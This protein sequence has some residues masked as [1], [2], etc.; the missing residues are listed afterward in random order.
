MRRAYG[1][2]V[3]AAAFVFASASLLLGDAAAQLGTST[4][5]GQVCIVQDGYG[6]P[7]PYGKE[8]GSCYGPP[9]PGATVHLT[10]PG[11]QGTPV[12][13]VDQ[14]A[15]TDDGGYFSFS[16]LDDGTYTLE[17]SHAGFASAEQ[18][19]EVAGSAQTALS[20]QPQE[21]D[22]TGRILDQD[23]AGIAGA[24]A[25]FCCSYSSNYGGSA[26]AS[27]DGEG[28]FEVTVLAGW[29]SVT[30]RA[31]GFQS[32]YDYRLVDG[33]PLEYTLE[34][35]PPQDATLTGTV[36][37]QDGRAVAN[38]RVFTYSYNCCYDA[39]GSSY[40]PYYG[41][42]N[43]TDT[44]SRGRYTLH[45]YSGGLSFRAEK[46]GYAP[47]YEDFQVEQGETQVHDVKILKYPEKNAHVSGR[48]TDG[49]TGKGLRYVSI[50][51][52]SPAFGITECS[53]E[54][55]SGSNGSGGSSVPPAATQ[56]VSPGIAY[57]EPYPYYDPGC[58]ITLRTDGTFEGD[59]TPGYT[60]VQVWYQ[61][62]LSCTETGNADGSVERT[63]GRDY[64]SWS[65]TLDLPANHDATVNIAMRARPLPDAV[66]SG[67]LVD[68]ETEEAIPGARISLSNQDNYGY[69]Y[70][71][72][73][74]DGSY[75]IRLRTGYHE[76]WVYAEGY[77]PWQGVLDVPVG[78]DIP[79][80]VLLTAGREVYG[81]YCCVVYEGD[82][83]YA[84]GYAGSTASP[85]APMATSTRTSAPS[86]PDSS[87]DL[88]AS[89]GEGATYDDLKGGLGPYDPDQRAREI[90]AQ[91]A[92]GGDNGSPGLG[93]LAVLGG[94]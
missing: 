77:L 90:E 85:G 54:A 67:Y 14:S 16:T 49:E 64:F 31:P 4:L 6:Y 19:V 39:Y 36:R 82:M 57:P 93:F 61:H 94:L 23:G 52:R 76:V 62:Y 84:H 66:V 24:E 42:E 72:T 40:A 68:A 1:A 10:K 35:V 71:T 75:R 87:G 27:S 81:G 20:L 70:A 51:V 73:D 79:F 88:S 25:E 22:V 7:V 53:T 43:W 26:V 18:E 47:L 80:D 2:Y 86:S 91:E 58:T 44:D 56:T 30:A 34:S 55:G 15:T 32:F 9:L 13:G 45:V 50:T 78:G 11:V 5:S 12:G 21:V 63:C 3:L 33:S 59:V 46:E 69:G 28:A 8:D 41:G 60:I 17:V 37:D 29:Y 92:G 83:G 48:V 74:E 65:Q 38:A 89:S